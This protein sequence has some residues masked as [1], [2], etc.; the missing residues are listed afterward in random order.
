[1]PALSSFVPLRRSCLA[2]APHF[3]SVTNPFKHPLGYQRHMQR[4]RD[5]MRRDGTTHQSGQWVPKGW[6][7]GP[8]GHPVFPVAR[9]L[10]PAS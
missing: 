8:A 10:S 4:W 7:P 3:V 2:G 5:L 9:P 1:M 6:Q